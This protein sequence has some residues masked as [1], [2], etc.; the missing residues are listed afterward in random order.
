MVAICHFIIYISFFK[1]FQADKNMNFDGPVCDN[2]KQRGNLHD[3]L[4][5]IKCILTVRAWYDSHISVTP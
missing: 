5:C 3:L 1:N 4:Y 2:R